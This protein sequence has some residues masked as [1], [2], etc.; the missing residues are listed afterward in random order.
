MKVEIPVV[1]IMAIC[2]T[3][4]VPSR[5]PALVEMK[6]NDREAHVSLGSN[7][8]NVG[9]R[10]RLF[11]HVCPAGYGVVTQMEARVNCGKELVGEG[12]I[13]EVLSARYSVA[14]FSEG[15]RIEE[16]DIIEVAGR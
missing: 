1:L 4:C 7:D 12:V 5:A 2:V 14:R 13:S 9:D 8:V 6:I 10:V 16:E 15:V 11:R 3:G